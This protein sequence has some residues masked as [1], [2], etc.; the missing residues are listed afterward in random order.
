MS[1]VVTA[2]GRVLSLSSYDVRARKESSPSL[3]MMTNSGLGIASHGEISS[4]SAHTL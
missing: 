2:I 3:G 4:V 1:C